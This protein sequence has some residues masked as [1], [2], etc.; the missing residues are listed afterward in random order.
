MITGDQV[1]LHVMDDGEPNSIVGE[2]AEIGS[3]VFVEIRRN[4]TGKVVGFPWHL[5]VAWVILEKAPF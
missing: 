5:I 3:G 2:V 1:E 4:D